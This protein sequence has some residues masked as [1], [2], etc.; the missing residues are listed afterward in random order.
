M[1]EVIIVRGFLYKIRE[2]L[3]KFMIGRHGV[4]QFSITMIYA[5]VILNLLALIPLFSIFST[6]ALFLLLYAL[7]RMLSKNNQK[8]YAE[9]A[10][11]LKHFGDLPSKARQLFA[12]IKNARTYVYFA[13]P[14]CKAKLR[15]PRGAGDVTVTCGRCG[16]RIQKKV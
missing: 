9:N 16:N 14:H 10:W 5:S 6:L 2:T 3:S 1:I 13:C 8:R 4:D 7:F 11:F 15:L 12:R